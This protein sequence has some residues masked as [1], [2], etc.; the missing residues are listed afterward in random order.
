MTHQERSPKQFSLL[1]L[2]KSLGYALAGLKILIREEQNYL[3]HLTA[4]SLAL[5]AGWWFKISAGEWIAVVLSIQLVLSLETINTVIEN[6]ADLISTERSEA[7][8]RIKDLAAASVLISAIAALVIGLII[9]VPKL[10]AQF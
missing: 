6:V 9:F 1:R 8:K 2:I 4:A 3:V 10:M 7:I 5:A